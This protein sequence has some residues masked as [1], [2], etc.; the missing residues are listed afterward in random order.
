MVSPRLPLAPLAEPARRHLPLAAETRDIDR[1]SRP[2]YAVWELT[3]RCDL[4]CRHCGSRAGRAR[5]DEL[6]TEQAL[7]M[8]EQL[9]KLGVLEI[10]LIGGEAY[11]REDWTTIARAIHDHGIEVN[12]VT[13]G[14]AFD[15]ARA[16]Q[17]KQVG[18]RNISVSID[19][20]EATH[21][22]LRGVA[23]SY[24]SALASMRAAREV[25][26]AV[27]A[28]TQL[29]RPA[30]REIEPLVDVLVAEGIYAWQ[31]AMTVPMGRAADRPDLLL[32]PYQVLEVLP[33]LVRAKRKLS[34]RGIRLWPGNDI[35]YFGP[36]DSILRSHMPGQHMAPCG[37]GRGTLGIEAD[38]TIKGCPS[39]PTSAYA[40]GNIRDA[41]LVDIWERAAPLRFTRD[42]TP[43]DL[44]GFCATCY[45]GED[46]M[47]G[48][49]WTSHVVLGK[50]GNNPYCHHRALE[51]LRA[52]QRE[53]IVMVQPAPGLPFDHGVF[54][55]VLEPWPDAELARARA[56]AE[57]GEGWLT[58]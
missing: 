25:G 12:L 19:A 48:C 52:G 8:V 28:N 24:R 55:I 22:M 40:G 10:S 1:Q 11:L 36:Y 44:W 6:S 32:E 37:A 57:T 29:A 50:I 58:D 20:L 43:A 47:G 34:E 49:S 38:G 16:E 5:P 42:R 54:D 33:M 35:G 4:A 15:R 9:A 30:L 7:D 2:A 21:D 17:A 46:C 26:L 23:G 18:V 45:Y 3:L 39:L 51:L 13:G 14:R 56:L 53:R 31:V 27:A 41:S